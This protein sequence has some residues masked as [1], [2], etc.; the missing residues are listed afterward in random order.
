VLDIDPPRRRRAELAARLGTL[1][2]GPVPDR[3]ALLVRESSHG[4]S[5]HQVIARTG[6]PAAEIEPAIDAARLLLVREPQPWILDRDWIAGRL[7]A[8]GQRLEAFHRANPLA[9]GV[10][11]EEIRSRELGGAPAFL[12]DALLAQSKELVAEGDLLR[13]AS[14]QLRFRQD[15]EEALGRMEAAF[16]QAGLAVPATNEVLAGCGVEPARGRSLLEILLRRGS[17]VRVGG[18]LVFHRSAIEA[19]RKLMAVHKGERFGVP[20]FKDWTGISR[21]YAIPLLE[22]LD[23]ERVTRREGDQRLVL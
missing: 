3:I 21:K 15:E 23:R 2:S 5:I 19:L 4:M 11:K 1:A 14:H 10:A 20:L 18:D 12:L 7:A 9:A 17:L 6:L 8:I 13:L 16:R 22:Y